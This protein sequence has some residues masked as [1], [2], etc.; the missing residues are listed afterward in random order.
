MRLTVDD[1]NSYDPLLRY[2]A[3]HAIILVDNV[4]QDYVLVADQEAGYIEKVVFK[5]GKPVTNASG[6][7][8]QTEIVRGHVLIVD[9]NPK[10]LIYG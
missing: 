1:Q 2:L 6:N 10:G 4:I 3:S 7:E 9:K 5:D 8:L